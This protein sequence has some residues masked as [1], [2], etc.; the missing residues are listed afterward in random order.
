ML[1]LD[2]RLI[3]NKNT[4]TLGFNIFEC[5]CGLEQRCKTELGLEEIPY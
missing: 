2:A 5:R 4:Y 1:L 3:S